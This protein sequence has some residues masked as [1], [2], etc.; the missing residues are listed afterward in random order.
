MRYFH[1]AHY[2]SNINS[3]SQA[4]KFLIYSQKFLELLETRKVKEAL[5]TLRYELT[6]LNQSPEKLHRLASLVMCSDLD[7][8]RKKADWPGCSPV[9]RRA[10]LSAVRSYVSA[11]VML[12]EH[13]Y[14]YSLHL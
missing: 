10:V 1:L 7:D 3:L 13:R 5:H 14:V 6:P 4:V 11:N 8:L 2:A 12:P 9:S